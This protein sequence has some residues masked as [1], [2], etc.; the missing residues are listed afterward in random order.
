MIW[1]DIPGWEDRYQVSNGGHVRS[2]DHQVPWYGGR[3]STRKGRVLTP[4]VKQN[5]YR[6]VTLTASSGKRIQIAIHRLVLL[7]FRGCVTSYSLHARHRDNDRSNN[8]LSNLVPGTPKQNCGDMVRHK[9]R[10]FG[11][12]HNMAVLTERQARQIKFAATTREARELA[13]KY[14]VGK[15]HAYQIRSGKC[16]SHLK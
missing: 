5:G 1:K 11:E 13:A 4:V 14:G 2:K 9:T 3:V 7:A 6:Y 12:T 8:R 10:R 16:W 15:A